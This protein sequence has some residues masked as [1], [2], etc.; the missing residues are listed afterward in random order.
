MGLVLREAQFMR[1]L[2]PWN[3]QKKTLKTT[4]LRNT[5]V[6]C[7]SGVPRKERGLR[8]PSRI[9]LPGL[10]PHEDTCVFCFSGVPRRGQR[11]LWQPA[12]VLLPGL[13]PHETHVSLQ[14]RPLRSER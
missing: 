11:G 10:L 14:V 3:V 8:Q 4:S 6:F 2:L 13:L 5:C 12:R 9:L 1:L 7:F